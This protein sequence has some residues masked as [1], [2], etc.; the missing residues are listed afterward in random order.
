MRKHTPGSLILIAGV[1]MSLWRYAAADITAFVNA[2]LID[3]TGQSAQIESTV[4]I[5]NDVIIGVGTNLAIPKL[6]NIHDAS[7]KWIV[8]GLIDAH[9]HF[10]E[11]GRIYTKPGT[12]DLTHLVPYPEEVAW[13]RARVPTT[14]RSYLCAGVTGTLSAGG[15]RFEF[16]VRSQARSM[17]DAP[18]VF[19]AHGVVTQIPS[20]HM[21]PRFD[22]DTPLRT[23]HD[24][25]S[26]RAAID[27]GADWQ[28]DLIKTGYIGGNLAAVEKD[29]IALHGPIVEAARGHGLPVTT[30]VTELE[31]ARALVESGVDSLQHV[32]MDT[33]IDDAFI[34]LL[35]SRGVIVVPTLAVFP[36]TFVELYTK[37]I[38]LE[39]IETRCGDPQVI[40]TWTEIDDLPT[41]PS[42]T[43]EQFKAGVV[44][45]TRNTRRLYDAGVPLAAGS[46]AGNPGLVH[47]ASLHY[48]L[49]L[50][51][52][53]GMSPLDVIQAAT[54]HSAMVTG[55]SAQYGTV[56]VGK[57]ADFLVLNSNPLTDIRN[58]A[59]IHNIIRH[60]IQFSQDELATKV[61]MK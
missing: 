18:S 49:K 57:K 54:L 26:A 22:G 13:M 32:P 45:A 35:K 16:D 46:D 47:G 4:L 19:V 8:P 33:P 36:R 23:I 29:L 58:L 53:M 7:G 41:V 24:P 42:D 50:L 30:H 39:E 15:P 61:H 59:D 28:A 34:A 9:A 1:A 48:E 40:R 25:T 56:E 37:S 27:Q 38:Q 2:T 52:S 17:P 31:A 51:A 3:G 5:Q 55:Q 21:F 43:L 12:I 20:D 10:F 44:L 14:L 6:A 60:G 11:S